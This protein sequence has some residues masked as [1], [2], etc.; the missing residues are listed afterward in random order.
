MARVQGH[1]PLKFLEKSLHLDLMKK[2]P[3]FWCGPFFSS[4]PQFDKKKKTPDFCEKRFL[5]SL[6]EACPPPAQTST[7]YL[8]H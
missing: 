4:S 2:T 3:N 6:L 5:S 1:L 7:V 8:R